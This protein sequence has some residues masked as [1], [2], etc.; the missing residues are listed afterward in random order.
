M[1]RRVPTRLEKYW[2]SKIGRGDGQG[3]V[4][5]KDQQSYWRLY[6]GKSQGK[7]RRRCDI[8]KQ[9]YNC[10]EFHREKLLIE[11]HMLRLL[12]ISVILYGCF[13]LRENQ[14]VLV[15]QNKSLVY[16]PL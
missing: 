1:E 16:V 7:R 3:D 13:Q 5:K 4:E 2:A 10:T 6:D 11:M 15:K 9:D 12:F 8:Y 14:R